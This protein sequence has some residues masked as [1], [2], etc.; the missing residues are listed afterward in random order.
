MSSTVKKIIPI[1]LLLVLPLIMILIGVG[2]NI[3]NAWYFVAA[4]TW[5]GAGVIFY[6]AI[7]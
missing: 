2:Y 5:F 3:L 4:V 1:V 6:S 7:N